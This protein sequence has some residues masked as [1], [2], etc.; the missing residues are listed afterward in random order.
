M[1]ELGADVPHGGFSRLETLVFL[2]LFLLFSAAGGPVR[3][4]R[5]RAAPLRH[6]R[7][8]RGIM[9]TRFLENGSPVLWTPTLEKTADLA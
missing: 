6:A 8:R 9:K 5:R 2:F 7:F 4:A 3:R 1:Q